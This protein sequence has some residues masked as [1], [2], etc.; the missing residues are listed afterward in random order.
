VELDDPSVVFCGDLVW[1]RFFPNYMD[2]RPS[3]L[4]EAVASLTR[5]RTT[6]Y[7]PGHGPM[8]NP[9]DLTLFRRLLDEIETQARAAASAGRSLEEAVATFELSSPLAEWFL[10]SD[11]YPE[12]ALGAWMRELGAAGP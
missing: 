2:A 7:V 11:R 8:A 9:Q 5:E 1:H 6:A 4:T 3:A 10:F 12:V